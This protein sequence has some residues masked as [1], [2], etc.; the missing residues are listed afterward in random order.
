MTEES[1]NDV[2]NSYKL[3]LKG[4]HK[5]KFNLFSKFHYVSLKNGSSMLLLPLAKVNVY[6]WLISNKITDLLEE[7]HSTIQK[8]YY[9]FRKI[10]IDKNK[11]RGKMTTF[12]KTPTLIKGVSI[13]KK[14]M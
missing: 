11:T 4:Y 8:K 2:Y 6:R 7:K 3:M 14:K 5:R 1:V 13:V 10:S 12:L 9:D